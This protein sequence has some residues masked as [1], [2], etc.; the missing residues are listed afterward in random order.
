MLCWLYAQLSRMHAAVLRCDAR[1]ALCPHPRPP[2]SYGRSQERDATCP[3]YISANSG[4]GLSWP[5]LASSPS[6]DSKWI[7]DPA[8][9]GI[10]K[11][12][13]RMS[14]S[15]ASAACSCCLHSALQCCVGLVP[16]GMSFL[17]AGDLPCTRAAHMH[18]P[19]AHTTQC[20]LHPAAVLNSAG[21]GS[22]RLPA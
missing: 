18:P 7:F 16:D 3:T 13:I 11:W 4:C 21:P 15:M 12:Y 2:Q 9:G 1:L 17:A 20:T 6:P 14:V 8:P 22:S 10:F 19:A 5:T